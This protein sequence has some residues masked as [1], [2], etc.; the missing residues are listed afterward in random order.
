MGVRLEAGR[1]RTLVSVT[2]GMG[3]LLS[4]RHKAAAAV[5]R[6]RRPEKPSSAAVGSAGVAGRSVASSGRRSGGWPAGPTRGPSRSP[7]RRRPA[8]AWGEHVWFE[9]RAVDRPGWWRTWCETCGK[10]L[11]YRHGDA[12]VARA[13]EPG[14]GGVYR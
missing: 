4:I 10:F 5:G 1:N 11:G 2:E 9:Q 8:C 14:P 6:Q 3:V 7:G 12:R 13:G